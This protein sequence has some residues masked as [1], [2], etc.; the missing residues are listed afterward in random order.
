MS[1]LFLCRSYRLGFILKMQG[2]SGF[3]LHASSYSRVRSV[4][5]WYC[6]KPKSQYSH[7]HCDVDD[8]N[9]GPENSKLYSIYGSTHS[10]RTHR[11]QTRPRPGSGHELKGQD[12][13]N[14]TL[15]MY[16]VKQTTKKKKKRRK[17][18]LY[19]EHRLTS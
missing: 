14:V 10:S 5:N 1:I 3:R 4:I 7:C 12:R 6:S 9:H 18:N 11:P 17:C 13:E 2:R 8:K 19:L 16:L 15:H